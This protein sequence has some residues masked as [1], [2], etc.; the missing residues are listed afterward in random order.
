MMQRFLVVL[1]FAVGCADATRTEVTD[2]FV[3]EA[4]LF[5]GEPVDNIH[6][7]TTVALSD[8]LDPAP[9]NDA[10]VTLF[11]NG[12]AYPLTSSGS[13]GY[14]HYAGSDLD[15]VPGDH[16]RIEVA[17]GE[18]VAS[19]E[20]NVPPPPVNVMIDGDTLWAPNSVRGFG[21]P[22]GSGGTNQSLAVS[23][24]NPEQL[25]HFVAIQGP[26][27]ST[28]T[29][30]PVEFPEGFRRFGIVSEPTVEWFQVINLF[31]L[32][33][34]GAHLVTV[35]RV[36]EEYD[37]LYRARLQDSRDLNEP[38]TNIVDGLGVFSA[39]SGQT[40]AFVVARE[41]ASN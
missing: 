16:F 31:T 30:L 2:F 5:A 7:T 39:F 22:G 1:L 25:S 13:E 24:D 29:I 4:Y 41:S 8:T 40:V 19:G 21:Q 20:T 35:Y 10:T 15:V 11:K 17:Y 38:P 23:W 32:E 3:V 34:L 6:L 9:I 36:N 27:D 12:T 18:V 14:Y 26:E 33:F 37:N 28:D